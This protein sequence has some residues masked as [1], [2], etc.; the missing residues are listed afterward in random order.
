MFGSITD[1]VVLELEKEKKEL[2]NQDLTKIIPVVKKSLKYLFN[3][4]QEK[5]IGLASYDAHSLFFE[6]PTI[7]AVAPDGSDSLEYSVAINVDKTN[8]DENNYIIGGTTA[9][10]VDPDSSNRETYFGF[11]TVTY[12]MQ[13]NSYTRTFAFDS[14][15]KLTITN[16]IGNQTIYEEV[17]LNPDGM[18]QYEVY[19]HIPVLNDGVPV[20]DMFG[21]PM[22]KQLRDEN[23][24]PVFDKNGTPVLDR[25]V[26]FKAGEFN[27]DEVVNNYVTTNDAIEFKLFFPEVYLK[28]YFKDY[29]SVR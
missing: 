9:R 7:K 19:K 5:L 2:D 25:D 10:Y 17:T 6:A 15:D 8:Q 14:A 24:N 13:G 21:N 26:V 4:N 20:L 11:L 12:C 27:L 18:L 3:G 16:T 22:F 28:E 1:E 29:S 23:G